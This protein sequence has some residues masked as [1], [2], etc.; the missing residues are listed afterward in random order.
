MKK[1]RDELEEKYGNASPAL[2]GFD[3]AES[4]YE[5]RDRIVQEREARLV[6]ALEF[7]AD[8]NN[9]NHFPATSDPNCMVFVGFIEEKEPGEKARQALADYK[10]KE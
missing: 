9:Y 1:L 4:I 10:T 7:Y 6:E 5:A 3:T 2:V 8:S